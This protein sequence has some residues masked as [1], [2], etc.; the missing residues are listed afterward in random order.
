VVDGPTN[1]NEKK[2]NANSRL[3]QRTKSD[4]VLRERRKATYMETKRTYQAE[5]KKAESTS[6]K[7]YCNVAASVNPWSQVYIQAAGKTRECGKMTTKWI[8]DGTE[9]TSLHE[10]ANVILDYLFTEDSGENNLH[11]KNIRKATEEPIHTDD[12]AEFTQEG[13]QNTIESFNHKKAP[14]P[15]G[16]TGGIYHRMF[17]VPQNN[18]QNIQPMF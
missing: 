18:H 1:S 16:I 15:D 9:T 4:E 11:H 14:R 3:Y 7:E 2:V 6:W 13:I 17:H 12:D 5:I 8:P 10:T